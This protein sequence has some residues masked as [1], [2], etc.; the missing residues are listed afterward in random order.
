MEVELIDPLGKFS[1]DSVFF[2]NQVLNGAFY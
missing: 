1:W 2:Y